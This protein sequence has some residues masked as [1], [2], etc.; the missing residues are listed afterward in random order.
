MH[1]TEVTAVCCQ[2]VKGAAAELGVSKECGSESTAIK[3]AVRE[4]TSPK[5]GVFEVTLREVNTFGGNIVKCAGY[6][7]DSTEVYSGW[8]RAR[9]AVTDEVISEKFFWCDLRQVHLFLTFVSFE[10]DAQ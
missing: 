5:K 1:S 4:G 3:N 7:V 10:K 6:E 2:V 8:E 9:D